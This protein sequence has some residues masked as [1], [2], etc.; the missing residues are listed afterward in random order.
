MS[1]F[2]RTRIKDFSDG[3]NKG[4]GADMLLVLLW[5]PCARTE[6]GFVIRNANHSTECRG[7]KEW[8]RERRKT[9]KYRKFHSKS[10]VLCAM[11][12]SSFELN[13]RH[14]SSSWP[15]PSW[16]ASVRCPDIINRP[17][18][19]GNKHKI[20]GPRQHGDFSSCSFGYAH[21]TPWHV[22]SFVIHSSNWISNLFIL[23]HPIGYHLPLT[24]R[25]RTVLAFIHLL[26]N[27]MKGLSKWETEERPFFFLSVP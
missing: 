12:T 19:T 13:V 5:N 8:A 23:H 16:V 7:V 24:P 14:T 25:L 18:T 10:Q 20:N 11:C 3:G 1:L 22:I 9:E 27:E 4:E 15:T 26:T 21:L 17:T 2:F 6:D